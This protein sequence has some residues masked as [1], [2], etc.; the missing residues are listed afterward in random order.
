MRYDTKVRDEKFFGIDRPVTTRACDC[1]GCAERGEYRAP[2]SREH[3]EEYYWFCLNHVRSYNLNWDYY[4][5]MNERQ[6]EA[7]IRDDSCWQ[8]ATWPLGNWRQ[9]EADLKE[10]VTR[11]FFENDTDPTPSGGPAEPRHH[12]PR[13]VVEALAVLDLQP[14]VDFVQIK[15]HYKTLVKRHHPDA[16]SGSAA[17]EA[18]FKDIN[19]AFTTLRK[20]YETENLA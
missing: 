4:A 18:K 5:G 14:P 6:I 13:A 1:P 9:R 7:H 2:K 17:A 19:Q 10:K 16:N 12:I 8:R 3:L 11:D 15:A 20:L